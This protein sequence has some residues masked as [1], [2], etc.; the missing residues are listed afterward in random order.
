MAP[1]FP[2]YKNIALISS[3]K[4]TLMFKG[5]IFK[6]WFFVTQK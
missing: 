4:V 1:R 3:D 2:L 6:Y 5:R